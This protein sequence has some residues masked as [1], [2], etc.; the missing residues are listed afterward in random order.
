MTMNEHHNFS[1]RQ[2]GTGRLKMIVKTAGLMGMLTSKVLPKLDNLD[3][4]SSFYDTDGRP[5]SKNSKGQPTS[6][7]KIHITPKSTNRIVANWWIQFESAYL[8]RQFCRRTDDFSSSFDVIFIFA[9]AFYV[10]SYA[11]LDVV[12]MITMSTQQLQPSYT[13]A[14]YMTRVICRFVGTLLLLALAQFHWKK[15]FD[16]PNYTPWGT[17]KWLTRSNFL[18]I[19]IT[20]SFIA[21]HVI[22]IISGDRWSTT[23]QYRLFFEVGIALSIRPVEK[24][25]TILCAVVLGTLIPSIW[26]LASIGQESS[27]NHQRECASI[28]AFRWDPQAGMLLVVA[29]LFPFIVERICH[30]RLLFLA[31]EFVQWRRL[32]IEELETLLR[33][34]NAEYG[35]ADNRM[36]RNS[37]LSA[38]SKY[39]FKTTTN[40]TD[41]NSDEE[42]TDSPLP[43]IETTTKSRYIASLEHVDHTT[44]AELGIAH[45]HRVLDQLDMP[46]EYQILLRDAIAI[47]RKG[48]RIYEPNIIEQL[49]RVVAGSRKAASAYAHGGATSSYSPKK[50]VTPHQL[51]GPLGSEA[52][53]K[54]RREM[55]VKTKTVTNVFDLNLT[56][57]H[58]ETLDID[59]QQMMRAFSTEHFNVFDYEKNP[60]QAFVAAGIL[61][62][63]DHYMFQ[64]FRLD[65]I[66]VL[67]TLQ[68]LADIYNIPTDVPYHSQ[69]HGV[70]VAQLSH[71]YLTQL[72]RPSKFGQSKREGCPLDAVHR[73]ALIFGALVHDLGHPGVNNSFLTETSSPMALRF[74][75]ISV[76]EMFHVSS[77]F[78][79]LAK[80]EC[81]ILEQ[82]DHDER[83]KIRSVMIELILAT[84]L[85]DHFKSLKTI[86]TTLHISSVNVLPFLKIGGIG[87]LHGLGN[88]F[89]LPNELTGVEQSELGKLI[90]KAADIGHPSRDPLTHQEWSRRASEEFWRQGDREKRLGLPVNPMNDRRET[91]GLA[92]G[93]MGFL[94]FLVAPTH[95]TLR[96]AMGAHKLQSLHHNLRD[97]YQYWE[98]MSHSMAVQ[99][100]PASK[101]SGSKRTQESKSGG[102]IGSKKSEGMK[103]PQPQ[104]S[105]VP[106]KIFSS[107]R[108]PLPSLPHPLETLT[109]E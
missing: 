100:P 105:T 97:N 31:L 35:V 103:T 69:L 33:C 80:P 36:R 39:S 70:D 62:L 7:P 88:G 6:Q 77:T 102:A 12:Y 55:L 15:S 50:S 24:F 104:R 49:S 72:Y 46:T 22:N 16:Q 4:E 65:E 2:S 29:F 94:S 38:S 32:Q 73:F 101:S 43:Y 26:F 14:T 76:L 59:T 8:Q 83:A 42:Q 10:L 17:R 91:K 40:E 37:N 18:L 82:L 66:K 74:N 84:D 81:N 60:K 5:L 68:R 47:M 30:H 25:Q 107:K 109:E 51:V 98:R 27:S 9:M 99:T 44:P 85:A 108:P 23:T 61:V 58:L 45:I 3:D 79:V 90:L 87:K 41:L 78:Q 106:R 63:N 95:L 57:E 20:I 21:L 53:K 71:L 19:D 1:D 67:R 89:S 64:T 52:L 28:A 75:D 13:G 34:G 96:I 92:K 56:N 93:Q 48:P 86:Q 54:N 11:F